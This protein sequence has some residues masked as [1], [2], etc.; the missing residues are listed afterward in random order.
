[1]VLGCW[2]G[3]QGFLWG[4]GELV[5]GEEGDVLLGLPGTEGMPCSCEKE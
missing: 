1:M 5:R 4:E 3:R 2:G